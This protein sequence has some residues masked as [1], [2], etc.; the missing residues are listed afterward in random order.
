MFANVSDLVHE[1]YLS[2]QIIFHQ[3]I[4]IHTIAKSCHDLAF[5]IPYEFLAI[6]MKT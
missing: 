3:P 6:Y 5:Y 1:I 2:S 4:Y